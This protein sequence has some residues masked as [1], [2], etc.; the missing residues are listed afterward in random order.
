MSF[1][2]P[3]TLSTKNNT[4]KCSFT[5]EACQVLNELRTNSL[6]CDGNVLT[7][8]NNE[9][10]VH[11]FILAA[12]SP[13]FRS[14]FTSLKHVEYPSVKL[15]VED[16]VVQAILDYAYMRECFLTPSNVDKIIQAADK[17]QMNGLVHYCCEYLSQ[18][19]SPDNVFNVYKFTIIYPNERLQQVTYD[20]LMYNFID[21]TDINKQFINLDVNELIKFISTDDLNARNE[22]NVFNVVIKWIDHDVEQRKQ[23][24]SQLI[25]QL[26]L[27]LIPLQVF[28]N[29][30]KSHPYIKDNDECRS[31]IGETLKLLYKL[32][33]E[34]LIETDLKCPFIRPRYPHEIIFA[35]GG[36][37][38][39]SAT[40]MLEAYDV[41]ADKWTIIHC[42]D[43]AAPRAYH[44]CITLDNLMYVIGGFDGIEYFS[45][46]RTFHLIKKEW[47]EIA[48][49]NERRCY[50]SVAYLPPYLYTMG[51]FNGHVRQ[52]TAEKY[53]R[54][55]NQWSSICPMNLQRS[56]AS[57][58]TLNDRIFI[59]GGFDGQECLQTA[60]FFDPKT[61]Q[62]TLISPMRSKRSGVGVIAYRGS[63][64]AIGGFNGQARLNTGERYNPIM[65]T[66]R[67]ITAM[68]HPRSNFAIEILDDLMFTIGYDIADMNLYRSALSAC[69]ING[70]TLV[71]NFLFYNDI[72][73]TIT[74][75]TTNSSTIANITNNLEI[76]RLPLSVALSHGS[77]RQIHGRIQ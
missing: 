35:F 26:R 59:C 72:N 5:D 33:N 68:L 14:I 39:G 75:T 48:P 63:V 44:G 60:E 38:G 37:S 61:N 43:R 10:A 57:A 69:V 3:A 49:M 51:G 1:D 53:D 19:L 62:W 30:V 64:Y 4:K 22:E 52:N 28:I 7:K 76:N 58:T 21:I 12:C 77:A 16:E 45:S 11:R 41:R 55:T 29:K 17:W 13:Y 74:T 27:G 18:N 24:I 23:Y 54:E 70:L 15:E 2:L 47:R 36:W 9:Y 67:P 31:M 42:T 40:N 71:K 50:V 8:D 32:D 65:N 46:C 20:Y 56:D 34:G 73:T 25:C 66:W 6:L